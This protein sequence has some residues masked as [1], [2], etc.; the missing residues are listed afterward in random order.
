MVAG[1]NNLIRFDANG[2]VTCAAATVMGRPQRVADDWFS[3][4][5]GGE[6]ALV[7]QAPGDLS[8][9][10]SLLAAQAPYWEPGT[11]SGYHAMTQGYLVGEVVRRITGQAGHGVLAGRS[12]RR[13]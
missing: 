2:R 1:Y 7:V 9:S 12:V 11:A 6:N 13:G 4:L 10:P 3:R 5:R 8:T